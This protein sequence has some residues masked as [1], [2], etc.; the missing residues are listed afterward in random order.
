M[1]IVIESSASADWSGVDN[2]NTKTI[3]KPT[4]LAVGDLMLA[5]IGMVDEDSTPLACTPPGSWTTFFNDVG[6][7]A[8]GSN[9]SL[10]ILC[11][12]KVADSGDA[13]ASNFSFTNTSGEGA[14]MAGIIYRITGSGNG[15]SMQYAY[16]DDN[17]GGGT[18]ETFTNT[19]TPAFANGYLFFAS[20]GIDSSGAH[21]SSGYSITTNN[22]TWSEDADYGADG[23]LFGYF[24]SGNGACPNFA[25][26]SASR[27]ETTATGDSSVTL[28]SNTNF[29]SGVMIFLPPQVNTTQTPSV[30]DL[31]VV[32]QEPSVSGGA[33]ISTSVIDITGSVIA[34]TVTTALPTWSN[35]DKN[36]STWSNTDKS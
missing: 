22:P 12:Y 18:T 36:T 15:A 2:N 26:A 10:K 28:S 16:D 35:T 7:T 29:I 21:T 8:S 17:S 32:V 20:V 19:L 33:S 3:T 5:V 34:P 23:S 9:G 31:T 25:I 27:P 13:A 24:G 14:G 4:G 6:N 30:L 1:A 11:F